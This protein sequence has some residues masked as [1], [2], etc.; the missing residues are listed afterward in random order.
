MC[1]L[2]YRYARLSLAGGGMAG[3]P[4][5]SEGI[6]Y[7][8]AY[9]CCRLLPMQT[10]FAPCSPPGPAHVAGRKY[11]PDTVPVC[12]N[13]HTKLRDEQQVYPNPAAKSDSMRLKQIER[14]LLG[15]RAS[16]YLLFSLNRRQRLRTHRRRV[17]DMMS[18][19]GLLSQKQQNR[20]PC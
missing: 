3:K 4:V 2:P 11:S 9:A 20:P 14:Y 1:K 15:D 7:G 12:E 19:M 6:P 8:S 17:R 18:I 13:C 10:G 16:P 5:I